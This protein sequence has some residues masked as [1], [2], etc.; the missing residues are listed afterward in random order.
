M[1]SK[2]KMVHEGSKKFSKL[3]EDMKRLGYDVS[4][5]WASQYKRV[6]D[7]KDMIYQI[8]NYQIHTASDNGYAPDLYVENGFVTPM[9]DRNSISIATVS[10]GALNAEKDYAKFINATHS[11]Y[12]ASKVMKAFIDSE[13]D[14]KSSL[15]VYTSESW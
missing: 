1:T 11:A 15:P 7:G 12:E 8:V 13:V 9:D 3:V 5:S 2:W 4:K 6:S 14:G 10:Y